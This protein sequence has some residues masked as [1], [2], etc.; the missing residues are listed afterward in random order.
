MISSA[1]PDD[2]SADKSEI[3]PKFMCNNCYS[4]AKNFISRRS[5]HSVVPFIWSPHDNEC[6]ICFG[7]AKRGRPTKK[8][9]GRKGR[10]P[11]TKKAT[12]TNTWS[13]ELIS[14]VFLRSPI[15]T[16][17]ITLKDLNISMEENQHLQNIL[18]SFCKDILKRPVIL[19]CGHPY[20]AS[21]LSSYLKT[22]SNESKCSSCNSRIQPL[23]DSVRPGTVINK[24]IKTVNV[25]L[26]CGCST[27]LAST[28][29]HECPTNI[30]SLSPSKPISKNVMEFVGQV[31]GRQMRQSVLPNQTIHLPSGGPQVI[32]THIFLQDKL[33]TQIVKYS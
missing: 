30:K 21:C 7:L 9:P 25:N 33:C 13:D 17:S 3:H 32:I 18:C 28:S 1:F 6:K 12:A 24:L 19:D 10:P 20:C 22:N 27:Q 4:K 31:V 8:S 14:A 23:E 2:L 29:S 5:I 15:D 16:L 26:K 11:A